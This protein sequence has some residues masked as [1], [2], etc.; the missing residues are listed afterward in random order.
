MKYILRNITGNFNWLNMKNIIARIIRL[1][2][3]TYR[4]LIPALAIAVFALSFLSAAP[5]EAG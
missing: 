5:A 2:R 3:N 1:D 4:R